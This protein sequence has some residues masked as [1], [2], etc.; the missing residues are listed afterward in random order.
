MGE[1]VLLIPLVLYI[2]RQHV[3]L[4][5]HNYIVCNIPGCYGG[6]AVLAGC[7]GD[8]IS[9]C[10]DCLVELLTCYQTQKLYK[11]GQEDLTLTNL[12]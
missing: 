5:V 7:P 11:C 1:N 6:A 12:Q 3:P 2:Q 10:D 8:C 9:E 4:H